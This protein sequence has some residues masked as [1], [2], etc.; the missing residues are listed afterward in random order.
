MIETNA[1]DTAVRRPFQSG[2]PLVDKSLQLLPGLAKGDQ[3]I[4]MVEGQ[5]P[6]FRFVT[7]PPSRRGGESA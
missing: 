1:R 4:N 6:V 3:G 7:Q 2:H 5:K